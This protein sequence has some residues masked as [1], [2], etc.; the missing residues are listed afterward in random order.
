M[1]YTKTHK[2]LYPSI[3]LGYDSTFGKF[4]TILDKKGY[5]INS[6]LGDMEYNKITNNCLFLLL[7]Q[8]KEF[9]T[10][11]NTFFCHKSYIDDYPSD[12]A[13]MFI[14]ECPDSACYNYFVMS[15]FSKMY[16]KEIVDKHFKSA[17]G[18][19]HPA[20]HI[21]AKSEQKRVQ[22]IDEFGFS[23][24]WDNIEYENKIKMQD[25]IY[26]FQLTLV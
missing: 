7:Q 15:R 2:Y 1:A 19:Y 12:T 17:D 16:K 25:E 24:D 4:L 18:I 22:L 20:Y 11:R 5:I 26:N 3:L 13:H 21:L 10:I 14:L 8:S 6:F 23:D 9:E